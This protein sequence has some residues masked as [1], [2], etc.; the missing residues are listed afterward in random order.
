MKI[1]IIRNFIFFAFI[2][3]LLIVTMTISSIIAK[4]AS[5]SF[6]TE[7]NDTGLTITGLASELTTDII[8]FV[9]V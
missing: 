6:T 3:L 4:A 7:T 8:N 9:K 5:Y 2:L 1:K